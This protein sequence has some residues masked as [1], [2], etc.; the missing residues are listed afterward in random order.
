MEKQQSLNFVVFWPTNSC[1]QC[2]AA[3]FLP[4]KCNNGFPLHPFRATKH[5]VT[6]LTTHVCRSPCKCPIFLSDFTQIRIFSIDFHT[7]CQYIVSRI[8]QWN[9]RWYARTCRRGETMTNPTDTFSG[10]IQKRLIK[11]HWNTSFFSSQS[12]TYFLWLT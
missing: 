12:L 9:T 6:L 2:K 5:F 8:L 4:S 1:Q 11:D 7:T 3:W 10:L